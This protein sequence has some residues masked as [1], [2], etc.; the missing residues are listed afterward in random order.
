MVKELLQLADLYP[1]NVLFSLL[2]KLTIKT[3][4]RTIKEETNS[5]VSEFRYVMD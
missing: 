2:I 4:K 1:K 5:N 3:S